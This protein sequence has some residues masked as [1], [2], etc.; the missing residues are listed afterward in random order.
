MN[1]YLTYSSLIHATALAVVAYL[2]FQAEKPQIYYGFQFLG[3]QSGF[4]TGLSPF[5]GRTIRRSA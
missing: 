5:R 1:R 2:N 4:G 3:G